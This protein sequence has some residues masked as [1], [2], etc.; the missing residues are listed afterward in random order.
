MHHRA[1]RGAARRGTAPTVC[2]EVWKAAGRWRARAQGPQA[3][4]R[5]PGARGRAAGTRG[6]R[7][8]AQSCGSGSTTAP[9]RD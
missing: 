1:R 6:V 5:H 7:V 2:R 9:Q 3:K 8:R 4:R